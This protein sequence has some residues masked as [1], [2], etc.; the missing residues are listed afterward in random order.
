MPT[1]TI[2]GKTIEFDDEGF[3]VDHTQWDREIAKV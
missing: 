1:R 3:M 2:N